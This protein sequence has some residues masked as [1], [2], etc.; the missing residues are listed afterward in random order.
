MT[1]GYPESCNV[2]ILRRQ[3]ASER[4][5]LSPEN[6]YAEIFT[7]FLDEFT[8]GSWPLPDAGEMRSVST[9]GDNACQKSYSD[10]IEETVP[11]SESVTAKESSPYPASTGSFDDTTT[12]SGGSTAAS[13]DFSPVADKYVNVSHVRDNFYPRGIISHSSVR[14]VTNTTYLRRMHLSRDD[15]VGLFPELKNVTE[16]VFMTNK[17]RSES[18]AFLKRSTCVCIHDVEGRRWPVVV[19][20]LRTAGQR[21]VRFNKG[22]AEMCSANGISIG[23]CILL[24]RRK[25]ASSSLG[26]SVVTVSLA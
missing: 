15:A 5:S 20:C 14:K 24:A 18:S 16:F 25:L 7:A 26:D 22:W 3:R 23:K 21:H 1:S 4:G 10:N 12:P 13:A 6:G 8:E 9:D 2:R 17:T 19:E 11:S